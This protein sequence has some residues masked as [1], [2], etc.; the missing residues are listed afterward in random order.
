MDKVLFNHVV[1]SG[2]DSLTGLPG[3]VEG[4][5]RTCLL[6][7]GGN[8]LKQSGRLD[9]IVGLLK[10]AGV[11][12]IRMFAVSGEPDTAVV[13]ECVQMGRGSD[14]VIGAGGGSALDTAKAAAAMLTNEGPIDRYLEITP[15]PEK[16]K[17]NPLPLIA[18]PTTAGTG[19]EAT[20]NAVI[21]VREN[22]LKASIRD[23][24]LLP[25]GVIL[26]PELVADV[27]VLSA[28]AA[29]MDALTQLIEAYTGK[30]RGPFLDGMIEDGIVRIGRSIAA[31]VRNRAD[32]SAAGDLQIAA[33]VSGLGLANI[34][35][36]AVH[37]LARPIGSAGAA[38]G[39][40]CA[41]LLPLV[42]EL[43][44]RSA[45][46]RYARVSQCLGLSA[47]DEAAAAGLSAKLTEMN[48]M[49]GIPTDFRS[50]GIR[51]PSVDH[52]I[53]AAQGGSLKNN[54][55]DLSSEELSSI[56]RRVI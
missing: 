48:R 41:V 38:H 47:F 1:L 14:F 30:K 40:V 39:L 54:P 23:P 56:I 44:W 11:N 2:T 25:E 43:N 16:L 53:E 20:Q 6:V 45:V 12:D 5:G 13:T 31:Y 28:A 21:I 51:F 42:T 24:R 34:G 35:L 4:K 26:D 55:R 3:L 15:T 22:F 17:E 8:S 32:K 50:T 7:T 33:Y 37:A 9:R 19:T 46:V 49:L 27:P 18:I 36:G 10:Q 52:I 29:G